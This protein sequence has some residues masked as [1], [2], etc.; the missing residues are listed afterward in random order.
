MLA[1]CG[2]INLAATAFKLKYYFVYKI[3]CQLRFQNGRLQAIG[4]TYAAAISPVRAYSLRLLP[5]EN[6]KG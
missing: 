2:K 3:P 1:P 6:A 5:M 4:L